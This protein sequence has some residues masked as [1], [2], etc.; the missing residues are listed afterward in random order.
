MMTIQN[1]HRTD[2]PKPSARHPF[3]HRR[4]LHGGGSGPH[5]PSRWNARSLQTHETLRSALRT[6][7]KAR[8]T[9]GRDYFSVTFHGQGAADS[10]HIDSVMKMKRRSLGLTVAPLLAAALL[11]GCSAQN[12]TE[13]EPPA[14]SSSSVSPPA[15]SNGSVSGTYTGTQTIELG[16]PPEDAKHISVEFVCIDPGTL[17]LPGGA[18]TM[19]G[20]KSEGAIS[21]TVL[22]LSPGQDTI[23]VKTSD[24][25]VSYEMKAA[26]EN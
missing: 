7:G 24:P 18:K 8:S 12:Q 6:D 15:I 13:S 23:K 9:P 4:N 1:V 2:C 25:T 21:G 20:D 26:Y 16:A 3:A 19:C 14:T 22:P 17:F 10:H 5:R 11:T